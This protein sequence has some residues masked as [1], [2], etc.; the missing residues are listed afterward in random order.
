MNGGKARLE[1]SNVGCREDGG[2]GCS[3]AGRGHKSAR[4]YLEERRRKAKTRNETASVGS[5]FKLRGVELSVRRVEFHVREV[6][7]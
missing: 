1:A 6:E 5:T 3:E 2:H 7:Y 4:S